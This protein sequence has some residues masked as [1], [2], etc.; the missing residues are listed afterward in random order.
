MDEAVTENFGSV[1]PCVLGVLL[2]ILMCAITGI[3]CGQ[4]TITS[5][6]YELKLYDDDDTVT[7]HTYEAILAK[8][9]E[10]LL[11][12]P[13]KLIRD[14]VN[15][16]QRYV[17]EWLQFQ[18]LWDLNAET[19]FSQLGDALDKW[20]A[21]LAAIKESRSTFDTAETKRDFGVCL[22]I[23]SGVQGKVTAKYDTW[24]REILAKYGMKIGQRMRNFYHEVA[25]ARHGLETQTLNGSS[26][27]Q[28]VGF[29]TFVQDLKRRT[30]AWSEDV[31]ILVQGQ[32]TLEAQRYPFQEDWLHVDRITGEWQLFNDILKRKNGTIQDQLSALQLKVSAEVRAIEE[33]TDLLQRDW[34]STKPIQGNIKPEI[35]IE[36]IEVFAVRLTKVEEDQVL[37]GQA[38]D[39]LNLT[40]RREHRLA[41]ISEEVKD[42][43]AVW[44]ALLG[45]SIRLNELREMLWTAV[46]PRRLRQ[47]LDDTLASMREMPSRMRQY[48][49]Y[50]YFAEAIKNLLKNN[51]IIS[52]LKSDALRDRHWRALFQVLR[53][54][55]A[56]RSNSMTLGQVWDLNITRNE[57]EIKGI[58]LQAQGEMALEEYVRQVRDTWA[59]YTLDL[60]NYRNKCRLIRG[61]DDLFTTCR[62][63]LTS[64]GSM[65]AS[66][67]YRVFEEEAS[68]LEDKLNRVHSLFDIWVDVQRQWVYLE[69]VFAGNADIK[70]LLPVEASRFNNINSEFLGTM[71]KVSKS[72]VVFDVLAISGIYKTF[73]RLADALQKIQKA[74][75]E[76]L[77]RE[78]SS[79]PRFFFLGDEDLLEIIGNNRNINR[80]AKHL[81]KM[82]AGIHSL[83]T[84]D[85]DDGIDCILS[86]DGERIPLVA[87]I[88]IN[89]NYKVNDWLGL[90]EREMRGTLRQILRQSLDQLQK[91][92]VLDQPIEKDALLAWIQQF[93]DQLVVLAI[94]VVWT[95]HVEQQLS[96]KQSVEKLLEFNLSLLD[97]LADVVLGDL[98]LL[99]RHKSEHLIVE[100]AHQRDVLRS[101]I[102]GEVTTADAF[103][104]QVQMRF[105]HRPTEDAPDK[106]VVVKMADA[107][108]AYGF[109][110]LGVTERLV[111]TP[112]TDK[113]YLTLTQALHSQCGGSPF[114]PAG[115]GEFR[116]C[117]VGGSPRLIYRRAR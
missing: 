113:C 12:K 70:H 10:S 40:R 17:A 50:E 53:I 22:V 80:V 67:Y 69:G 89:D 55:S 29:I 15:D 96:H 45:V 56:Y 106:A 30:E 27:A 72:P 105:Y 18:S 115:T 93:P 14:K 46:N 36:T 110:Y 81:G 43:K 21:L 111:Q 19:I 103:E 88:S 63:Q 58:I 94:Q 4:V 57:K 62:D 1:T 28:A 7:G 37:L 112:L 20:C 102:H 13:F 35:A 47:S 84:N 38:Q 92:Y 65:R 11:S 61:W 9:D 5:S 114:G 74:L 98:D 95:S 117:C 97:V 24:Q 2:H 59:G 25:K 91:L 85:K 16:V 32:R 108:L 60:I 101:L 31:T 8:M 99:E 41:P 6:K 39:A 34:D 75:G 73:E 86:K 64:L 3:V 71:A 109:E 42:L 107:E 76:Y 82:F 68:V 51:S 48:A 26:T 23:Y 79:F 83:E 116:R 100:L 77:E 33:R 90:L 104:W 87:P 49:A 54:A 66:P 44:T 78:R 52:D